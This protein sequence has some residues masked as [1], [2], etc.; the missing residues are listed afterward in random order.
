MTKAEVHQE[1]SLFGLSSEVHALV[2]DLDLDLGHIPNW[3]RWLIRDKTPA[4]FV[5][6]REC[7][8]RDFLKDFFEHVHKSYRNTPE[9]SG[10]L[11]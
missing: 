1:L 7:Q 5:S 8:E 2:D 3:F 9:L 4:P 6:I 10:R 11:F